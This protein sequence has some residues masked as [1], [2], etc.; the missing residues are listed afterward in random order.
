[1]CNKAPLTTTIML[2]IWKI[3]RNKITHTEE[4]KMNLFSHIKTVF[5]IIGIALIS[6]AVY[7]AKSASSLIDAY[8]LGTGE[9]IEMIEHEYNGSYSYGKDSFTYAPVVRFTSSNGTDYKFMSNTSSNSST[10]YVGE[11]VEVLYL[12]SNPNEAIIYSFFSLWGDAI[13]LAFFGSIFSV[14]GFALLVFIIREKRDGTYLLM[15]GLEVEAKF[16]K[17]ELNESVEVNGRNPYRIV[18]EW[19]DPKS[20]KLFIYKS[21]NLWFD[22]TDYIE[23]E[24]LT[25]YVD[26]NKRKKHYLGVDFL[27]KVVG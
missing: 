11:H 7:S 15:D 12:A 27:P 19:L 13:I 1:M 23:T 6:L 20:N 5:L 16:S 25:V 22:P 14:I 21:E 2:E 3:V 8:V 24:Y 18:A 10:Y 4:V 9:V 26:K 17:V